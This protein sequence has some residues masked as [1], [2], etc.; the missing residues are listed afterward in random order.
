MCLFPRHTGTPEWGSL[1][2]WWLWRDD[3]SYWMIEPIGFCSLSFWGCCKS[4]NSPLW[5][6]TSSRFPVNSCSSQVG[7][8]DPADCVSGTGDQL[9]SSSDPHQRACHFW[10]F[11]T[12]LAD[13]FSG[14]LSDTYSSILFDIYIY[15]YIFWQFYLSYHLGFYLAFY[16]TFYLA[17]IL[18]FY[19]TFHLAYGQAFYLMIYLR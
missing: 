2:P 4:Q 9:L 3:E 12:C 5:V 10:H 14:I 16:L 8:L 17:Y 15:I 13:L 7:W 19:L 1:H 11:Y 6:P 18:A